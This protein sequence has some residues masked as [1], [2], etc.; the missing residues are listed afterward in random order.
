[1]AVYLPI[2]SEFNGKGIAKAR[3]EFKSLE[4]FGAKTGFA[5]KKAFLPAVAAVGA[6][7]AAT[8]SAVNAALE[9][10]KSQAELARV[11]RTTIRA[12]E[13]V[14]AANEKFIE[15][16]MRMSGITDDELRPNFAKLIRVTKD[17]KKAQDTLRLAMEISRGTGKDLGSTTDALAKALGGNFKALKTLAPELGNLIKDGAS[18]EEVFA[19][20]GDTFK[21]SV[22]TYAST[23]AGRIEILNTRLGELWEQFGYALLP[24]LEKLMPYFEDFAA[25]L[26]ANPD[27]IADMAKAIERVGTGMVYIGEGLVLL[28]RSFAG[29]IETI[30]NVI[31][32]A[33]N[34]IMDAV[35]MALG[36][37]INMPEL[38][39]ID[40][41]KLGQRTSKAPGM[42]AR[43]F[44][45]RTNT[46]IPPQPDTRERPNVIV[47]VQ[48]ADPKAVVDAITRWSRRNP[49][50]P[51]SIR[52][53]TGDY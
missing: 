26:E 35:D 8:M 42:T 22:S 47:N 52:T 14:I 15:T 39:Y 51:P 34:S 31:I 16:Q 46:Y 50:L 49:Q 13:G 9:D 28:F 1:M 29:I 5:L 33:I 7:G 2:I 4:G 37:F 23:T 30:T 53:A 27:K 44:E 18:A 10:A 20:L 41:N 6:I 38:G 40:F 19:A 25:W 17:V 11:M 12:T 36:P 48:G 3:R 45:Q 43:E 24:A 21:G 32:T